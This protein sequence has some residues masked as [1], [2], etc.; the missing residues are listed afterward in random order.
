MTPK[1]VLEQYKLQS[2]PDIIEQAEMFKA[3]SGAQQRELLF[4]MMA[5][6]TS[7]VQSLHMRVDREDAPRVTA[8][9]DFK[10]SRQ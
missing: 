5:H 4:Y 9:S 8:F 7:A 6:T 3:L 10:Q 2:A 1:E